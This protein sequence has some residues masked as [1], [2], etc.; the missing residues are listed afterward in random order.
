MTVRIQGERV[1]KDAMRKVMGQVLYQPHVNISICVLKPDPVA[2]EDVIIR[3]IGTQKQG[4]AKDKGKSYTVY[5]CRGRLNSN[6]KS[7]H[8]L[9]LDLCSAL[10]P[11]A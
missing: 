11:S 10:S 9:I 4:E 2:R 3:E 1:K 7:T 8:L 5:N 6:T